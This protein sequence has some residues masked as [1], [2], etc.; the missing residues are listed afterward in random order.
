[1]RVFLLWTV[2]S[3]SCF[4]QTFGTWSLN[5]DR[6]TFAGDTPP[7]SLT[8]RIEPHP[9]GEVFTF[10]RLEANGRT[11]SV[12]SILYLD[13]KSRDFRDFGCSG[14]QSSRR[15]DSRTVEILRTCANGES[16]RS[17]R[18]LSAAPQELVLEITE[19]QRDGRRFERRLVLDKQVLE[20]E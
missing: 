10:D 12:S 17:I 13:G 20:K 6:S 3:T 8:I 4:A 18:R 14:T 16:T 5:P 1:M 19:Q 2:L 9:K 7:K 11:T 15:V